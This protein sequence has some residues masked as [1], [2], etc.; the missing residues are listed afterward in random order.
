[1]SQGQPS[2]NRPARS[3]R[4]GSADAAPVAKSAAAPRPSGRSRGRQVFFLLATILTLCGAILAWVLLLRRFEEP[5]FL[6]IPITEYRGPVYPPWPGRSRTARHCSG[7]FPK[8]ARLITTR[9]GTN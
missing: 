7:I 8:A 5:L 1:M 6:A 3:W 4:P 2:P 9:N